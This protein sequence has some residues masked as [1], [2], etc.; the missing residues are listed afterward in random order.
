LNKLF[1]EPVM[2]DFFAT[3]FFAGYFDTTRRLRYVNCGHCPAFLVHADGQ[4]EKLRATA[5][6]L[7]MFENWDCTVGEA[8]ISC[9]D[10][11]VVYL[12]GVNEARTGSW[13]APV[14]SSGKNDCWPPFERT[15]A[16]PPNV[17]Q[18]QL[19]KQRTTSAAKNRTTT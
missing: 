6:V 3:L 16:F 17:W 14:S 4:C 11:L 1:Y 2:V 19:L 8:A 18:K 13:L 10:I 9:G 15:R 5:T 7:G 12:D